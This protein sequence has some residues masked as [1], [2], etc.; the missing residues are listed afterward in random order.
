[1]VNDTVHIIYYSKAVGIKPAP[2]LGAILEQPGG[3][4]NVMRINKRKLSFRVEYHYVMCNIKYD[5][6]GSGTAKDVF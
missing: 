1:M 2:T 5:I 4:K 3:L 6:F